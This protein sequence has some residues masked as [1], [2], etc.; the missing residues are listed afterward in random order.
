ML[1]SASALDQQE[2]MRF[3][4]TLDVFSRL[5]EL[6]RCGFHPDSVLDVGANEGRFTFG[7]RKV[8]KN[9]T[10]VLVEANRKHEPAL[11][12]MCACEVH[13]ALLAESSRNATYLS[14]KR[15]HTANGMFL[16]RTRGFADGTIGKR[17]LTTTLDEVAKGRSF[18]FVKLDVQGAELL[19]LRG[20][21]TVL[22][23]VEVLLTEVSVVSYNVGAP[24]WRSID[25]YMGTIGFNAFDIAELHY[26]NGKL[27]QVD[28]VYVRRG[29][30]LWSC[31]QSMR[32]FETDAS[33]ERSRVELGG[34]AMSSRR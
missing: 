10:F 22:Q 2:K 19:V 15:Y 29:S 18:P 26:M 5:R 4:S 14:H 32:Q 23:S 16:Q 21:Q 25:E 8:F 17:M 12:Q 9:A 3:T 11:R 28:I 27:T 31:L 24:T 7:A 34:E 13:I 1:A 30:S 6:V 33:S 20:A